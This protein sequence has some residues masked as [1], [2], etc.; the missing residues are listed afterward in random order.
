[1][2]HTS[3]PGFKHKKTPVKPSIF[4][5][6]IK[7]DIQWRNKEDQKTGNGGELRRKE[8]EKEFKEG[9]PASFQKGMGV[10]HKIF[11]PGTVIQKTLS[12]VTVRFEEGDK[13]FFFEPTEY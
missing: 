12:F 1:M 2:N 3:K 11:G 6:E 13:I 10:H 9:T 5:S 8:I 7:E 4:L